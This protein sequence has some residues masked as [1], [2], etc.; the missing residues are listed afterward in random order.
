MTVSPKTV[1]TFSENSLV[2][3]KKTDLYKSVF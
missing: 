3:K 1:Q 2:K